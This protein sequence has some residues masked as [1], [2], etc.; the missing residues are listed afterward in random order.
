M[1]HYRLYDEKI[2][3]IWTYISFIN[4]LMIINIHVYVHKNY[5]R[6]FS[7]VK[8]R[9]KK[10]L[11]A[12][13][14]YF[15]NWSIFLW[16]NFIEDVLYR[17]ACL[18]LIPNDFSLHMYVQSYVDGRKSFFKFSKSWGDIFRMPFEE[19]FKK[20]KQSN[21]LQIE[22]VSTVPVWYRTKNISMILSV[23]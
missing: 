15:S 17:Y 6:F 21:R 4:F 5:L 9:F 20:K 16:N 10:K 23:Y 18:W 14:R 8:K 13:C 3:W 11:T 1:I 22:N 2:I 7:C 19:V 12:R